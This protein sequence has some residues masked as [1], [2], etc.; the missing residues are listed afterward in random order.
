MREAL[1]AAGVPCPLWAAV[2]EVGPAR[3]VRRRGR[4]AA[5]AQDLARRLRRPR[6]VGA[7]TRRRGRADAHRRRPR[8]ARAPAGWPRRRSTSSRSSSAQVA[9]SPH[10][11]AVAYPVVRTVQTD[12]ICTEVVAPAPGL[13]DDEAVAAQQAALTVAEALDVVGHARG[14]DVR[15][16]RRPRARQRARDA[17]A[18]LRAL[19]DRRRGHVAVREP[20][21]RRARPAARRPVRDRAVRRD[22]QRARRRQGA[23][24]TA[25]TCTA[26]RATRA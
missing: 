6:R 18:Q 26:W 11:Q 19:V 9:R 14:R 15:D 20:P 17:P 24:C 7:S 13:T 22:G 23:T 1:T 5:G 16:A 3:G 2:D 21:A 4:L 25:P 8:S 10:G 12:G